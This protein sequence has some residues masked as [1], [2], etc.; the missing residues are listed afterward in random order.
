[1]KAVRQLL[2][3]K[4]YITPSLAELLGATLDHDQDRAPHEYLSNREFEVMMEL[5]A[6][7]SVSNIA[8]KISL[9]VTSISTCRARVMAKLNLKTNADLTF[10]GVEHRII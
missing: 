3:G 8:D 6:G 5:A 2:L 4:K 1:M 9:S 7:R 10:Y